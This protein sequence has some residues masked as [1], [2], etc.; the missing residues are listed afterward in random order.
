MR[1][2]DAPMSGSFYL[3]HDNLDLHDLYEI[4]KEIETYRD[5]EDCV[6]NVKWYL[7]NNV[8]CEKIAAAR[9]VRAARE[10][11]WKNRFNSLFK[12]IKNK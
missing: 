12:I 4:G 9:R 3:N 5:I 2:F 10:H 7:I 1:D 8:E 11:T 6:A